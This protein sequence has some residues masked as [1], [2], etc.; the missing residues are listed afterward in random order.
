MQSA[1]ILVMEPEEGC[2]IEHELKRHSTGVER[3]VS[4]QRIRRAMPQRSRRHCSNGANGAAQPSSRPFSLKG[5]NGP[6]I[7]TRRNP[8]GHSM[9]SSGELQIGFGFPILIASLRLYRRSDSEQDCLE[10]KSWI[11]RKSSRSTRWPAPI[12]AAS[13]K[14]WHRF[15]GVVQNGQGFWPH[16]QE[17][18][19]KANEY[20]ASSKPK[21]ATQILRKPRLA[22]LGKAIRTETLSSQARVLSA[23]P[24]QL[25]FD[26]FSLIGDLFLKF[27]PGFP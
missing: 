24:T 2:N 8:E 25:V 10:R 7:P 13:C 14:T 27:G 19:W 21:I 11:H 17:R 3:E 22:I 20:R 26:L 23:A 6:F 1:S 15:S 9:F 18:G 16:F 12:D 5:P 4:S